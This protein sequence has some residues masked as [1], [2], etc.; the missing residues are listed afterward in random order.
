MIDVCWK[1]A[2]RLL[3]RVNTLLCPQTLVF[4][5]THFNAFDFLATTYKSIA[6]FYVKLHRCFWKQFLHLQWVGKS[7]ISLKYVVQFHSQFVLVAFSCVLAAADKLSNGDDSG[8]P[9]SKINDDDE[10]LILF[11]RLS[12][13]VLF[14]LMTVISYTVICATSAM[15]TITY[16]AGGMVVS[17]TGI[18]YCNSNSSTW[19]EKYCNT[20]CNTF[21]QY[22]TMCCT[23]M[24]FDF[25]RCV[26]LFH[27][28]F[29]LLQ[30]A[31]YC[32][33]LRI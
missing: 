26:Q 18:K 7:R 9:Q 21:L 31:W 27:N 32:D 12:T 11:Q 23:Q 2:G 14:K 22:S 16:S 33:Q 4:V 29:D 20:D 28:F 25:C 10:V 19:W 8:I 24:N 5:N 1:F 17:N 3:D 6:V 13:L 15:C 30:T